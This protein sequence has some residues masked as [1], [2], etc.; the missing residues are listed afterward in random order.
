MSSSDAVLLHIDQHIATITLNRPARLNALD[1]AMTKGLMEALDRIEA[2]GNSIGA[3]VLRG[4]GGTFMAGGDVRFFHDLL[5]Q[6]D[7]PATEASSTIRTMINQVHQ[8]ILRLTTLPQPVIARVDGAVAGFGISLMNA[9]DL[10]IAAEDTIFT[11]AYCHIGTSPDGGATHSLVRLVGMK[12][13]KEI[14]LLGGRFDAHEAE[15]LGLINQVVASAD[16][17]AATT[18]LAIRLAN[19]PRHALAQTKALLNAAP[20]NS[21]P[22]Q[23]AAEADAFAACTFDPDFYEGVTAFIEKRKPAFGNPATSRQGT[24]L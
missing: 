17:D 3:V 16:L 22:E 23:L 24:A 15:R 5:H 7:I 6:T 20:G 4:S 2:A 21:L 1:Q 9:C 18:A 12:K 8:V 11:L 14:A 19:G 13:A 10:A